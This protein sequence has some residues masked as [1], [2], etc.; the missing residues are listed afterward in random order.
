M[1]A[2]LG[3]TLKEVSSS[4]HGG[5]FAIPVPPNFLLRLH[6]GNL[7]ITV[8]KL[9]VAV[10]GAARLGKRAVDDGRLALNASGELVAVNS[11]SNLLRSSARGE[12]KG[13]GD[14]I[15]RL[16]PLVLSIHLRAV[17]NVEGVLLLWTLRLV[18]ASGGGSR[19]GHDEAVRKLVAQPENSRRFLITKQKSFYLHL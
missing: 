14:L 5:S 19:S 18:S 4:P 12:R 16:S 6:Q 1:V 9:P 7:A 8:F 17:V 11:A 15:L 10:I 2:S 13:N 3:K